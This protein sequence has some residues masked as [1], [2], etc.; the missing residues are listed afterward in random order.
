MRDKDRLWNRYFPSLK[1][2]P[3]RLDRIDK[4]ACTY[5]IAFNEMTMPAIAGL[6]SCT[7]EIFDTY[8]SYQFNQIL[9][10]TITKEF[11]M[12]TT[13]RMLDYHFITQK[14]GNI[15][16]RESH[17]CNKFTINISTQ[18]HALHTNAN[19]TV[20]QNRF[21]DRRTGEFIGKLNF[22]QSLRNQ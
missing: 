14:N 9:S 11:T 22:Q 7:F 16:Y 3:S 20:R 13:C 2:V 1:S 17:S 18:K 12:S 8:L 10:E 19:I 4:Q 6:F 15:V 21:S 5:Q